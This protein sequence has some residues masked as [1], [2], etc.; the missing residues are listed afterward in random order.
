MSGRRGEGNR[1]EA[2]DCTHAG[3][4][5]PEITPLAIS[6]ARRLQQHGRWSKATGAK[7]SA[8]P[9]TTEDGQRKILHMYKNLLIAID[10]S[11][12]SQRAMADG[13]AL[14]KALDAK[15]TVATVIVPLLA[16][17]PAEAMIAF[18]EEEYTRGAQQHA[19]SVLSQ[20]KAAADEEGVACDT[21]TLTHEQ[22]WRAIID[23]ADNAGCDLIVMGSHGRSGISKLVMGSETQKVLTHTNIPVLVTR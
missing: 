4:E 3:W 11:E 2:I 22:P 20:A 21:S 19:D 5:P 18:P 13:I 15:I 9:R 12:L 17:A 7:C 23:A 6:Q 1:H 8:H 16:V 10:G 14:A